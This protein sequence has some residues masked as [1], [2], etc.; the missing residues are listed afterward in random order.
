MKLHLGSL[1]LNSFPRQRKRGTPRGDAPRPGTPGG[2][3]P[4][5]GNNPP[6]PGAG[7]TPGPGAPPPPPSW[8]GGG[9]GGGGDIYRSHRLLAWIFG[10][11]HR[12]GGGGGKGASLN[13][14][15]KGPKNLP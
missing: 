11:V 5:G 1:L 8:G 6:P 7:Q 4:G 10:H 3:P 2:P 14:Q 12:A 15:T 9:G 13:P